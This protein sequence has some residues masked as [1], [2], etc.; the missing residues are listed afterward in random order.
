MKLTTMDIYSRFEFSFNVRNIAVRLRL[1]GLSLHVMQTI[2]ISESV[3]VMLT[4]GSQWILS[5]YGLF[6]LLP[7]ILTIAISTWRFHRV[8]NRTVTPSAEPWTPAVVPYWF[9][10]LGHLIEM[11]WNAE[12]FVN[13]IL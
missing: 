13:R 10:F 1:Q 12:P 4:V 6:V 8:R 7:P 5:P 11:I 3:R 2:K 9:P